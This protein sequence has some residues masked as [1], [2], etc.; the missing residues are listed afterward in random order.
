MDLNKIKDRIAKLLATA[1][2]Q[3]STQGEKD[4]AMMAAQILM[5]QYSLDQEDCERAEDQF[6]RQAAEFTGK[7]P[8]RWEMVLSGFIKMVFRIPVYRH[9][10]AVKF[11]GRRE[12]VE[13]AVAMYRELQATIRSS[14]KKNY[15]GY[16]RGDG[17]VYAEGFVMGLVQSYDE[18]LRIR[19]Q[20]PEGNALVVKSEALARKETMAANQWLAEQGTRLK[21][22]TISGGSRTGSADAYGHGVSDGQNTNLGSY[23]GSQLKLT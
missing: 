22:A 12:K 17:A 21:S 11:Y 5:D 1:S 16:F 6:D 13:I 15:G 9:G 19:K 8:A 14:A 20:T 23:G 3:G 2:N 4:N 7:R 18:T 10:N